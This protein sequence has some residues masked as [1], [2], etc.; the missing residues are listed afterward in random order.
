VLFTH[1]RTRYA[2]WRGLKRVNVTRPLSR[3]LNFDNFLKFLAPGRKGSLR[4]G[5]TLGQRH[6]AKMDAFNHLVENG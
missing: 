2:N 4:G 3:A 6:H 1:S 5:E